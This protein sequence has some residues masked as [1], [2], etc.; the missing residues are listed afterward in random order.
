MEIYLISYELI[1]LKCLENI[2][3]SQRILFKKNS[4]NAWK[5]GIS[6]IKGT[7]YNVTLVSVDIC[8]VLPRPAGSNGLIVVKLKR[9]PK[10]RGYVYFEPVRPFAIYP[11]LDYLKSHNKF[12]EDVFISKGLSNN[13][14]LRFSE[15]KPVREENLEIVPE[16]IIGNKPPLK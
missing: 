13:Q 16:R 15:M 3:I 1:Y 7:I 8:N 2:F 4:N 9:N 12:Y 5:R 6:K 10:Y 11:T 14:M